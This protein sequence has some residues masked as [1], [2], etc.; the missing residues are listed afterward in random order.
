MEESKRAF[1]ILLA[2]VL[3][4]CVSARKRAEELRQVAMPATGSVLPPFQPGERLTYDAYYGFIRAATAT[5]VVEDV[6]EVC[7]RPTYHIVF[8]AKTIPGFSKIFNVDDRIETF[9]DAEQFIPWKFAKNLKEGDYRCDEETILDQENHLG[10]YRSNRSGYTKEYELP[11]RC[12]DTLSMFYLLRVLSYRVGDELLM[13]VMADEEIWDVGFGVREEVR[14]TVY[15]GGSYDTFLL[16]FNVAFDSGSLRKGSSR[17]WIT[18]DER[19]LIAC[20]K[21]KLP[22][23]YL[24][25]ALLKV[26]NLREPLERKREEIPAPEPG[27]MVRGTPA[28]AAAEG[29]S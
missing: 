11:E 12:Q 9:I 20:V 14:R 19:R 23:G 27:I 15:R 26:E 29:C 5:L 2:V 8:T 10:H 22:F 17:V 16:D 7:G 18:T 6:V 3:G 4:G 21:T 13:K 1:C 28:Q 24:T 25:L